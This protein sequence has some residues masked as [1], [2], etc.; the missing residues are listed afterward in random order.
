MVTAKQPEIAPEPS[1]RGPTPSVAAWGQK[2]PARK[3]T[4][5]PRKKRCYDETPSHS[6]T[7]GTRKRGT[8][9]RT[10][11]T[12][13]QPSIRLIPADAL[14]VQHCRLPPAS[15]QLAIRSSR[16]KVEDVVARGASL[17]ARRPVAP[18]RRHLEVLLHEGKPSAHL[19]VHPT[20][21]SRSPLEGPHAAAKLRRARPSREAC[22]R[23]PRGCLRPKREECCDSSRE[24][25]VGS[26]WQRGMPT[27]VG[28]AAASGGCHR[29]ESCCAWAGSTV[30]RRARGSCSARF[31]SARLRP[32]P[33]RV[34]RR[35][36][37][38]AD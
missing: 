21:A 31:F 17:A 23:P 15:R 16:G 5:R 33:S 32:W 6:T 4:D 1:H 34:R 9:K 2:R 38:S 36:S 29:C 7:L 14:P 28:S 30:A 12:R 3:S 25:A 24:W 8:Q 18:H 19:R 20:A 10:E 13:S 11:K 37:S 26:N 27:S 22:R 35:N